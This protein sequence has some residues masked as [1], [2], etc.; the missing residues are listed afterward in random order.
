MSDGAR[1]GALCGVFLCALS[2]WRIGGPVGALVSLST[3]LLLLV[4]PWHG[5]PVWAW[6]HLY[7][8]RNR[9]FALETPVTTT[10]D[11][12]G[13][14]VRYQDDVVVAAVQ[15]LGRP[16]RPTVF[17]GSTNTRS[18]NCLDVGRLIPL[19]H[20][21]LGLTISSLS[22]VSAGS[23][24]RSTGDYPRVYD[25]LIGNTPYAG[26]REMWI[27]LRIG[28][29]ENADALQWR[30]TAGAAA[31]AAAQRVAAELRTSG[32][33]AKVS[34][35]T[36]ITEFERRLGATALEPGNRRWHT[37]R[38]DSG[39]LTTYSYRPQDINSAVLA[40]AWSLRVDGVIQNI[41]V[42]PDRHVCASVTLRT[43]APPTASPSTVFTTRPGEQFRAFA[44]NLCGPQTHFRRQDCS[45]S[46]PSL[47]IPV[48]PTGVLLGKTG[49][50]DRL[51]LPLT[52]PGEFARIGLAADDTI[53]KRVIIRT[54]AA[55]E[56]ITVHT[57]DLSRWESVRMP[58]VF[59][60]DQ[61]RPAPGTTV[62]VLDGSVMP[63]PRPATVMSVHPLD[64]GGQYADVAIT[65]TGPAALEVRASGQVYQVEVESFRAEN[66][67]VS[68]R[69]S[70]DVAELAMAD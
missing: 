28:A 43:A 65:Q 35:A 1:L 25:T 24:R 51:L 60:T 44:S 5:K 23:R 16:H 7:V 6:V 41:T 2:G 31:L 58:N 67:Y 59:V 15:V 54:A 14:G 8:A 46:P 66:H 69:P 33:R 17:S 20:Q 29:M 34:T 62:S 36:D 45:P 50:G 39:W 18:E 9:P 52:N 63:A 32:I 37:L 4:A 27:V 40:Q 38:C 49:A 3:G 12:S 10:N 48:G 26:Q 61:P 19:M 30:S 21:S 64:D 53:A 55:G 57:R 42:F 47:T 56:R 13:G 11:R 68:S 70:P 22:I